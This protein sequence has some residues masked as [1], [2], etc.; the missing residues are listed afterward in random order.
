MLALLFFTLLVLTSTEVEAKFKSLHCAAFDQDFGEFLLCKLKAISRLRNSISVQYKLKQPVS[1]IFIRLEFFKR[2]NGWRP[3]L[4]NF[5]ANLC[6]FLARNNN[7]IM[8]IGYA[9]LRP[10]LVKNYSC[11]FKVIENELLE[12]KDFELDINNLRN[13]FPIETGEYALQLTFIAK[14][15]AALTINGSI[16]YNNY[17]E[18]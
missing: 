8:G 10:Y 13:R 7:V 1:K 4:Y 15:K 14:N 12:C 11:P 5:T 16:E 2:A 17:R 18:Y 3:F 6:D 9:Y